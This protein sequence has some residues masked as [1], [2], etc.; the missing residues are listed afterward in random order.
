MGSDPRDATPLTPSHLLL[1]KANNCT[2]STEGN[3][4]RRRW[5][6]VQQI[7]NCFYE[8]FTS[9]YIPQLQ[10]RSKWSTVKPNLQVND[11]VLVAEEDTRR[12]QWPLGII[13]EVELSSDGLVRAAMVRFNG[14]EKRRPINKLV[15][16]EHHT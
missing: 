2:P 16:L 11:I 13:T 4:V 12:G 6:T 15:F 14:K 7:A 8:R 3:H 1:L 10:H 9:E 5:Q